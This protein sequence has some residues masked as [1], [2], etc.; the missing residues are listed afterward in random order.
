MRL[1]WPLERV[2]VIDSDQGKSG[3]SAVDREGFQKLVTEVS[4]GHAG[5]V[6]GLEVSRLARNSTDWH[7]LLEICA[8]TETL[9]L[10][11]DGLYDPRH[12]NDRLL[13]GMKGTLSET[14]LHVLHARLQ[15]GILNKARRGELRKVL[16]TGLEYDSDGRVILDPD[17]QIQQTLQ[18]FFRTFERLGSAMAT[19]KHFRRNNLL[20][21]RRQRPGMV[22]VW[23]PLTHALALHVLR[24]PRYAGCYVHGQTR[25]RRTPDGK[26]KVKCLAQD[27]WQVV[28]PGAHPGYITWE[29]YQSNRRTLRNN[30][31]AHAADRRHPPREG[32]A[33]LQG[34]AVC[35]L[36]GKPMT[37][38]YHARQGRLVPDYVCQREGIQKGEAICQ[39]IRGAGV[40]QAIGEILL[41][42]LQPMTLEVS[43]AV[44]QELQNRLAE[45]DRLRKQHVERAR[46]EADKARHRFM[47]V[48]PDNRL[49][50]DALEAE[51]NEKLRALA[52]AQ[53]QYERQR[54]ADRQALDAENQA[55]VRSLATTFPQLWNDPGT[56]HRDRKR[57]VQL[58][59]EDVT[60]IRGEEITLHIR[61][62][63]GAAQ[64]RRVPAPLPACRT[65]QT[66]PKIVALID[67]LLNRHTNQR[68]ADMLNAEGLKSGK[69]GVFTRMTVRNIVQ[70]HGL[71]SRF[72]RLRKKGLQTKR[73]MAKSL[74]ISPQTVERWRHHGILK[75]HAYD[76]RGR[77][78]YEPMT[79][80]KPS[81]RQGV[82]LTDP[83]RHPQDQ[84]QETE[85]VQCE[86]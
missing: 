30:S 40:D 42:M 84:A 10:D 16:P 79:N 19:V 71:P 51:W 52:E 15:G 24:N 38:R 32:P 57:M 35:G 3:S 36:C 41:S 63:G 27:E 17:R 54:Q 4:L 66:D 67:D 33:L 7:R 75:G 58:L 44:Q 53:E 18:T 25:T 68:I 26:S 61:F 50:A 9:I 85:E 21:P 76:D 20:F 28:L 2:V 5:I 34:L 22:L 56:S 11:E 8:L 31:R 72:D 13:L 14:E 81:K 6:L 80:E 86:A 29:Q 82:K 39:S 49:V 69:G 47:K 45:S 37:I 12:F 62:K 46:Y 65:W 64:T 23:A 1:G 43:A 78:L 83:R 70:S 59:I 60:L 74:R 55:L 73:E 77:Y 48:D